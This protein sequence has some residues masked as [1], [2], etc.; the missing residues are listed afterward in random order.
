MRSGRTSG[1]IRSAPDQLKVHTGAGI[2]RPPHRGQKLSELLEPSVVGFR[3]S[4]P[5]IGSR[6]KRRIPDSSEDWF[7]CAVRY[8][9]R[10]NR[11][12]AQVERFLQNKG[13][14]PAQAKQVISRL[15]D[16]RY[17]DDQAYAR[18]WVEVR[19]AHQPM[20]RERLGLELIAKGVPEAL[21]SRVI[22]DV[23]HN[24]DEESL[25]R[26]VLQQ[27]CRNGRRLPRRQAEMLLRR[28]GFGEET[29]ERIMRDCTESKGCDS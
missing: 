23:L 22:Q 25:A 12:A 13:A 26:R 21:V 29:I 28:R 10:F 6:V 4:G 11:T 2:V 8:L 14:S 1:L 16:L 18:H 5:S 20:G 24:V 27:R 7:Q 9:A 3:W 15:S 19:L 17:L